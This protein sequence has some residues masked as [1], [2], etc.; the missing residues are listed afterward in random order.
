VSCTKPH[1]DS[2]IV[3]DVPES[4]TLTPTAPPPTGTGH[5][6]SSQNTAKIFWPPARLEM[7]TPTRGGGGGQWGNSRCIIQGFRQFTPT[8]IV[9][10]PST[11][12][13]K[14]PLKF[15]GPGRCHREVLLKYGVTFGQSRESHPGGAGAGRPL[16]WGCPRNQDHFLFNQRGQLRHPWDSTALFRTLRLLDTGVAAV[17]ARSQVVDSASLQRGV[18][19][20]SLH[21]CTSLAGKNQG[22]EVSDS[23]Q[24]S[25]T[26]SPTV[27]PS[28]PTGTG[29]PNKGTYCDKKTPRI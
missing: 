20:V 2:T 11:K 25:A 16:R 22:F 21:S 19:L 10:Q 17:L 6:V 8:Q 7:D 5:L 23:V 18:W 15:G 9:S 14:Q 29:H 12:D 4:A 1:L 13:L 26:I 24:V 28:P 3:N 27:L